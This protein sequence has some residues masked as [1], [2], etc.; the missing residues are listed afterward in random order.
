MGLRAAQDSESRFFAYVEGL[1]SVIGHADREGPLRDYCTGLVMPCER[2]SVEPM[3]A[4]T[5][6]AR[7]TSWGAASVAAAFGW[8]GGLVGRESLG[9][10]TRDG[11]AGYRA[12]W[13]G[14][15]VD[16]RRH[17]LPQAG[18]ALGWRSAAI[19]RPTPRT[20]KIASSRWSAMTTET[21]RRTSPGT[22][23]DFLEASDSRMPEHACALCAW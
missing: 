12:P 8:R 13:A 6:P 9:Q 17:R 11:A 14:R 21:M 1:T 4:V 15:G 18:A 2:K 16:H 7:G 22:L 19:L 5:A 20:S 3:A 23:S 10:S